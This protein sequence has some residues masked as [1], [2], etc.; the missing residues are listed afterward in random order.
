MKISK[1]LLLII[2]FSSTF[3]VSSCSSNNSVKPISSPDTSAAPI[4]PSSN[5]G[6]AD[7]NGVT[8]TVDVPKAPACSRTYVSVKMDTFEQCLPNGLTYVQVANVL[9]YRGTLQSK[10]GNTEIWQWNDGEGK[11]LSIVFDNEKLKSKAQS[12]LQPGNL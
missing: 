5:I 10:S 12:S 2:I 9:G 8:V 4:D 6:K 3:L 11:Y 7:Q 1:P